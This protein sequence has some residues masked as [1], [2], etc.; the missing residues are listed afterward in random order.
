MAYAQKMSDWVRIIDSPVVQVRWQTDPASTWGAGPSIAFKSEQDVKVRYVA[1]IE[2]DSL[3]YP[4]S[5]V[6]EK[7]SDTIAVSK[8]DGAVVQLGARQGLVIKSVSGTVIR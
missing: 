2:T 4:S 8:T 3:G 7:V 5:R 6:T 1:T